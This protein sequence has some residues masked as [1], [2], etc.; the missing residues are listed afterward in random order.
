[1]V[2]GVLV[3]LKVSERPDPRRLL[4][5]PGQGNI[6]VSAEV[7]A[8]GRR[9]GQPE[10]EARRSSMAQGEVASGWLMIAVVLGAPICRLQYFEL[11]AEVA[12]AA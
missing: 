5:Q 12:A 11:V 2:P 3:V 10:A 4:A 6:G 7:D 1:M 8:R 9:A